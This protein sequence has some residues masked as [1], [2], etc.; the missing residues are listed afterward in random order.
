MAEYFGHL[1]NQHSGVN[2]AQQVINDE[3]LSQLG[4]VGEKLH[5]RINYTYA[6]THG[7]GEF[8]VCARVVALTPCAAECRVWWCVTDL[9][10]GHGFPGS[11]VRP[12][13]DLRE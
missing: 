8:D 3:Y 4:L 5:G 11:E 7:P 1:V 2:K 10:Y 12:L 6:G 9:T 13:T